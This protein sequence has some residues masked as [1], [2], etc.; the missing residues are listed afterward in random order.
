MLDTFFKG[1]QTKGM[2]LLQK[3]L[4]QLAWLVPRMPQSYLLL[5]FLNLDLDAM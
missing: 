5:Q 4:L 3:S 1:L 2:H